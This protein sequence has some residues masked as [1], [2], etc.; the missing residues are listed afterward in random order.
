MPAESDLR[1]P[2]PS[3]ALRIRDLFFPRLR[4]FLFLRLCLFRRLILLDHF[5]LC[6]RVDRR[7]DVLG[8]RGRFVS[9]LDDRHETVRDLVHRH[10]VDRLRVVDVDHQD[11]RHSGPQSEESEKDRIVLVDQLRPEILTRDLARG[12]RR[13]SHELEQHRN[14]A[15]HDL[16]AALGRK[17]QI[18]ERPSPR[19]LLAQVPNAVF[20][21]DLALHL[22][23]AGHLVLAALHLEEREAFRKAR[24]REYEGV[25]RGL[26][27][28]HALTWLDQAL[29]H[30]LSALH[31]TDAKDLGLLL[32][33]V[34]RG[35]F[36]RFY[37]PGIVRASPVGS[38][39]LHSRT[40]FD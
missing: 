38:V 4:L 22:W 39:L 15:D 32:L 26:T 8:R 35:P 36:A 24:C 23:R 17:G 37:A 31:D 29:V 21:R 9:G 28:R 11:G 19:S 16:S 27:D 30:D 5:A 25:L 2:R 18:R 40:A 34:R 6:V 10:G 12:F 20:E 33:C 7:L 14:V 13:R 1:A 3:L